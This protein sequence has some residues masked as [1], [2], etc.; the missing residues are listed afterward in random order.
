MN[1]G[2]IASHNGTNM[3]A[4]IKACKEGVLKANPVVVISNNGDSGALLKAKR[5][6]IPYYHLSRKTH[7]VPEQLDNE[8][9]NAL[10]SNQVDLVILAGYMCRLGTKTLKYYKGRVINIHP[11]LLPK[12]GGEGMYGLKVHQAVLASGEKET[13]VTIHLTDEDYDHGAII[14]QSRVPVLPGDTVEVLSERVLEREHSFLVETIDKI[15]N[16]EIELFK[17]NR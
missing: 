2:F 5:E 10:V 8:I 9:L 12:H 4:V 6:G 1:I 17:T 7:P 16:G 11:A 15:I 3:Q 13:G 14:A